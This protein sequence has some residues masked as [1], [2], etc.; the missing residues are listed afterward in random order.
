[1]PLHFTQDLMT[2]PGQWNLPCLDRA[3]P[4]RDS[5]QVVICIVQSSH[6]WSENAL[7]LIP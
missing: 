2:S 5:L 3:N 6:R 7:N 1:M 4:F